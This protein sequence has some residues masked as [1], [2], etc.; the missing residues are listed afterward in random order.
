MSHVNTIGMVLYLCLAIFGGFLSGLFSRYVYLA[1]R[2]DLP[3]WTAV[4][5]SVVFYIPVFWAIISLFKQDDLD[6]FYILLLI[7]FALGVRHH[8]KMSTANEKDE[9]DYPFDLD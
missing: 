4:L 8:R 7:S 2:R 3:M 1:A 5:S 6:V 9:R